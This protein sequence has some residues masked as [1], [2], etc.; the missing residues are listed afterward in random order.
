M[1]WVH[2]ATLLIT[3]GVLTYSTP[4][5]SSVIM[6]DHEETKVAREAIQK[7]DSEEEQ[8]ANEICGKIY[9]DCLSKT[10]SYLKNCIAR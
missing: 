6:T 1:E 8:A 4:G 5:F 2:L 10:R 3:I 7:E 9:K